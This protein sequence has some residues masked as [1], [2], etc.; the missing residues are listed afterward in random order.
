MAGIWNI[1][2]PGIAARSRLHQCWEKGTGTTTYCKPKGSQIWWAEGHG[3]SL[4]PGLVEMRAWSSPL[5]PSPT[6]SKAECEFPIGA[7][8]HACAHVHALYRH[9]QPQIVQHRQGSTVFTGIDIMNSPILLL[10]IDAQGNPFHRSL[11][12]VPIPRVSLL[13]I[14]P[15]V[16]YL[17]P[18]S[19]LSSHL[20]ASPA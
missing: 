9:G 18:L 10:S 20:P 1:R 16:W 11:V 12:S 7:R 5:F 2:Q 19:K 6:S 17:R 13:S 14:R 8:A 3:D 15:M 4:P